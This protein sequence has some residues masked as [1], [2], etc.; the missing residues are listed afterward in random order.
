MSRSGDQI[1]F[2][3]PSDFGPTE[4]ASKG[5]YP[6]M[7]TRGDNR[8][9][10]SLKRI[11]RVVSALTSQ[12]SLYRVIEAQSPEAEAVADWIES[13]FPIIGV[14]IEWAKVSSSR[15]IEWSET[16]DLMKA[17]ASIAQDLPRKTTMIVTWSDA[18]YPSLEMPLSEVEK[19]APA[20]FES[21]FDTWIV[22]ESEN[23]CIEVH[24][25]GTICFGYGRPSFV[26]LGVK[27]GHR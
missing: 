23:W 20:I 22:C 21:S 25:E 8:A 1:R 16:A 7:S 15:C 5:E 10:G 24:H 26:F 6:K 4:D 14:Q 19:A 12:G 9:G 17:F 3:V 27:E 11:P 18:L 13:H 2:H